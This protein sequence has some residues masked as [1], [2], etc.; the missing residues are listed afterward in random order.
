MK[1]YTYINNMPYTYD[2]NH[3]GAHYLIGEKYKNHGEFCESVAKFH[4]GLEYLV[5][6]ATSY[7]NGSDIESLNA[8][9]KS[10]NAT[11]ADVF[12]NT[13]DS[14]ADTYFANVH[15]SLFI[16]IIDIDNEINEYHMNA[17]EF[18]EFINAWAVL[19]KDSGTHLTK[20]RFKKTSGKMIQWLNERVG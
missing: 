4:R 18:R 13:F 12:G 8:S 20:I 7:D 14:I 10:S 1:L 5:N 6:P 19:A 16:Y 15:S 9:V 3:R 2:P 17:K 11:L